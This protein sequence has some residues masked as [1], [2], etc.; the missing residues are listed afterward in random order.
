MLSVV[1]TLAFLLADIGVYWI[2]KDSVRA[3]AQQGASWVG[4]LAVPGFQEDG[5]C[6]E[7]GDDALD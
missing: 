5:Q 7:R 3:R 1:V 4:G 6:S 2:M